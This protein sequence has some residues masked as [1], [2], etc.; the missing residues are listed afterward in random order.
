MCGDENIAKYMRLRPYIENYNGRLYWFYP[1]GCPE[2][3]EQYDSV[4]DIEKIMFFAMKWKKHGMPMYR[5][6]T[7]SILNMSFEELDGL[8]RIYAGKEISAAGMLFRT[9]GFVKGVFGILYGKFRVAGSM[10]KKKI[11]LIRKKI[12]R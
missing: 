11:K 1:T 6:S 4:S 10:V 9:D 5:D 2:D 8:Y 3:R 12:I 7:L